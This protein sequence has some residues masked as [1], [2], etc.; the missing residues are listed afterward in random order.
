MAINKIVYGDETLVDL[1]DSKLVDSGKLLNGTSAYGR[2]GEKVNGTMADNGA[3]SKTL[4][5]ITKLYTIPEGY[6]NG[7]GTVSITTQTKTATP[8]TSSQTISPDTGK[9][10]SSVTVDAISTQTKTATPSTSSQD[11][12]PDTGKYLSKV[13][14]S[15]I[16]TQTKTVTASREA[17]TVTPDTG[18]YLTKVTVNKFPDA[19]GTFKATTRGTAVDMTATNNYRYVNTSEVP[20]DVL[21]S[22]TF[23]TNVCMSAD[24][25]ATTETQF[26]SITLPNTKCLVVFTAVNRYASSY[27]ANEYVGYR[28]SGATTTTWVINGLSSNGKAIQNRIADLSSLKNTTITLWRKRSA[29]NGSLQACA[30]SYSY[31]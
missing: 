27:Y 26:G 10:L 17:Q 6:H 8:S 1:T 3:V 24:A 12:T 19:T 29:S 30:T 22:L 28:K 31:T 7:S 25:D 11:I 14:V 2:S 9:V 5:T 20:N 18:K 15:A 23:R 13:T 21:D 16:S 4:N